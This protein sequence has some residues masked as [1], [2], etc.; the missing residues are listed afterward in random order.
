ML[1]HSSDSALAKVDFPGN[2]DAE[3]PGWDGW[4]EASKESPWVPLG[5]SGWE[6]GVTGDIKKKAD[7]D[8]EKSLKAAPLDERALIT[9]VFVTPRRWPGKAA[10]IKT[11]QKLGQW[12][13]VRAYDASD[14]ERWVE[15]S[16][17]AQ[18]WLANE[19]IASR[20]ASGRWMPVG[21]RGPRRRL[22]P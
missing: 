2:D 11:K 13:D 17:P 20:K 12:G 21:R 10:W 18:A 7:G 3:R 16:L 15:Q 4:T 9:F 22:H 14:L 1:V 19:L 5:Q 8:F 6:F